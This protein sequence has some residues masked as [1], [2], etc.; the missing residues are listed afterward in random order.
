MNTIQNFRRSRVNSVEMMFFFIVTGIFLNSLY[1]LIY[2]SKNFQAA[3]LTPM[4]A[5]IVS[6]GRNVASTPSSLANID[7]TCSPLSTPVDTLASKIRLTGPLCGAEAASIQNSTTQSIAT[8]F[9]D[10]KAL[11][12]S[13]DYIS[14]NS[15]KNQIHFEFK[16]NDGKKLAQDLIVT[17]IP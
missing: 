15:G 5:N 11:K 1:N 2:E 9:I 3:V 6:E 12:Y 16:T 14:L 7:T 8:V 17:R 4:T 13:T 10:S